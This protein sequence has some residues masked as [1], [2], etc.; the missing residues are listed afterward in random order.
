MNVR[1]TPRALARTVEWEFAQSTY[2]TVLAELP[3]ALFP[4]WVQAAHHE[5]PGIPRDASFYARS[6]EG[7]MLFFDCAA[8]AGKP[9]ALPSRA[10]DSVWHA[11]MRMDPA[12]L[13]R[14]CIRHVG[15][16]IPHVGRARMQEG[17]MGRA[18][19]VCLVQARRRA[20]QPAA[21]S[22]LPRLFSLDSQLGMPGGFGYR[23]IGGLVACSPLDE[24]GNPEDRLVFPDEL[25]PH[26]LFLSGLVSEAEYEGAVPDGDNGNGDGAASCGGSACVGACGGGDCGG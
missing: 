17:E 26:A 9:C 23:I 24:F 1:E 22:H 5:F 18:L 16:S 20:W 11:W 15:R 10:A 2:A 12:G 25:K 21:G 19:A 7:L 8:A 4:C 13:E 14:F 3:A 6:A